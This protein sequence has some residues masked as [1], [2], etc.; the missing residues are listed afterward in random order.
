MA[1]GKSDTEPKVTAFF[2]EASQW[3]QEL[4]AL[5]AILLSCGLTE[6]FKWRSPVYTVEG[7]NVAILWGLKDHA[8]LGFF[9]GVLLTDRAGLL[10]APGENSRSSR[11]IRFTDPTEVERMAPLLRDYIHE[12]AELER[13]GRKVEFPK[14]DLP[15]PNELLA[16]LDEDE[17]FRRTFQALTPGR[18]RGYLLHFGQAKTPATRAARIE[19]QAPRILAGKGMNDR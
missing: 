8:A 10:V 2:A 7:A 18:R 5:R 6:D 1:S 4:R 16:R 15:Y 19:R 17:S 11:M 9:K 13:A 12:A 14:D 3:Q